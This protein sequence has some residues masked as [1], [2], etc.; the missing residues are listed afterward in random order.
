M[1]KSSREERER[2]EKEKNKTGR[3]GREEIVNKTSKGSEVKTWN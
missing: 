1:R 3:S 2:K